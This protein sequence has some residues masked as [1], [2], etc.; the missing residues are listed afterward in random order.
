M[1]WA[2]TYTGISDI[3]ASSV[4]QSR[5]GAFMVLANAN[6]VNGTSGELECNMYLVKVDANGNMLWNKTY[7]GKDDD[8]A[9]CI[10]Q[11][12]DGGY[13]LAGTTYSVTDGNATAIL[14]KTDA[15]GNA[16]WNK[17]YPGVVGNQQDV[18]TG[19]YAHS[20]VQTS[21]GGYAIGAISNQ[22]LVGTTG[23]YDLAFIIKTDATGTVQ[24]NETYLGDNLHGY[25]VNQIVQTLDGGYAIGGTM[26]AM[27]ANEEVA[28][29]FIV[30]TDASGNLLWNQTSFGEETYMDGGV[31]Y[32]RSYEAFAI[33]QT[34]D[35]GYAL[36]GSTYTS[37]T[38]LDVQL[39]V[40]KTA[41]NGE[42]GLAWTNL[43]TN[44]ITMYRGES[45]PYWNY[46]RVRIWVIK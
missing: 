12:S 44:T 27:I 29:M 6:A 17:T 3:Y 43:T 25:N 34:R 20:V 15:N 22:I 30:K 2:K 11:T 8:Y 45:D 40:F 21:D 39:R 24:W 33:I 14:I 31:E 18:F 41:V 46:V 42:V 16:L 10:I 19:T 26:L 13:T 35:G 9:N 28:K 37:R 7:G 1:I 5:D 38:F 23:Y 4:V 36:A 32:L